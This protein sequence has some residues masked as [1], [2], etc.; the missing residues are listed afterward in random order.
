MKRIHGALTQKS[1]E[2]PN[3]GKNVKFLP[4]SELNRKLP[5]LNQTYRIT[6]LVSFAYMLH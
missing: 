5:R 3:Y 2:M 6:V 1:A 4:F